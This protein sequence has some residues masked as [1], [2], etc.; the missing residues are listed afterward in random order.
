MATTA[1][2]TTSFKGQLAG[3][4]IGQA[5]KESDTIKKGLIK[6]LSNVIGNAMLPKVTLTQSLAADSCGW[7]PTGTIDYVE[8]EVITKR[9]SLQLELCKLDYA[10]T[11]LAESTGTHEDVPAPL[12][13]QIIED[14]VNKVG[15]LIDF[16]IWQGDNSTLQFNGLIRQFTAD[17]AVTKV[18]ATAVTS[19]NVVAE[20]TKIYNAIPVE[21]RFKKETVIVVANDIAS[22]YV[23]AQASMGN[24]TS[25]GDKPL[26]FAGVKIEQVGGMPAGKAVAYAN[27]GNIAF[28][29]GLASE[30]NSVDVVDTDATLLDNSI[31]AKMAFNAG[32]GYSRGEQIVLYA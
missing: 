28:A 8:K 4:L 15:E 22:A 11:Y 32:V 30:L 3:D 6:V 24:N 16:Q 20:L 21:I 14:L 19:A 10:R 7:A 18:V 9:Y 12:Q 31:R 29:T 5:F 17:T 13:A 1:N 26:D 2:V 23:L 25:V 27:N